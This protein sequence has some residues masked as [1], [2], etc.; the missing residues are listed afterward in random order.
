MRACSVRVQCLR[1]SIWNRPSRKKCQ[2][3]PGGAGSHRDGT[4]CVTPTLSVLLCCTSVSPAPTNPRYR[5]RRWQ[6]QLGRKRLQ[7]RLPPARA[8]P[9]FLTAACTPSA[10]LDPRRP[11]ALPGSAIAYTKSRPCR[12]CPTQG[13]Q[14]TAPWLA[15]ATGDGRCCRVPRGALQAPG[16]I[17]ATQPARLWRCL[18]TAV[19]LEDLDH[20][21][22]SVDR[23]HLEHAAVVGVGLNVHDPEVLDPIVLSRPGEPHQDA[24]QLNVFGHRS[25]VRRVLAVLKDAMP[26][27]I[28]GLCRL[29]C[30]RANQ[31]PRCSTASSTWP[32]HRS[33]SWTRFSSCL[34]QNRRDTS[35]SSVVATKERRHRAPC[36]A[37]RFPRTEGL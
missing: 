20:V 6:K 16:P 26:V 35:S 37:A 14:Q 13:A 36:S 21:G 17:R 5:R 30:W 4:C 8:P 32:R 31:S 22:C 11:P 1:G 28:V 25:K 23:P 18:D 27:R 7:H 15:L 34:P 3:P 12:P 29:L 24:V 10:G 19:V 2:P 33:K 9:A